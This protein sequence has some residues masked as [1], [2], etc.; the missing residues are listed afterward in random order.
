[1]R[2]VVAVGVL[3]AAL[4]AGVP[5]AAA[6][7][8][9]ADAAARCGDGGYEHLRGADGSRF[10]TAGACVSY[11]AHGGVLTAE[12]PVTTTT[13]PTV[14]SAPPPQLDVLTNVVGPRGDEMTLRGK[15]FLPA[16]DITL[17]FRTDVGF[18]AVFD[19]VAT[20]DE[21][22]SF[23]TAAGAFAWPCGGMFG[24]VVAIDASDGSTVATT[25]VPILC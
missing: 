13:V 9:N 22:G 24:G 11:A 5:A 17:T 3:A 21:Q 7:G 15:G 12:P 18:V 10:R 6:A 20:T 25:T 4:A 23:E 8:G 14:P 2:T 19:G 1:M 16:R